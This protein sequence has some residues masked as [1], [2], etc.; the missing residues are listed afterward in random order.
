M[1]CYCMLLFGTVEEEKLPLNE[2]WTG[3][4]INGSIPIQYPRHK[5][6]SSALIF[7]IFP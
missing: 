5:K 4:F 1:V 2:I 3:K 7:D 6:Y